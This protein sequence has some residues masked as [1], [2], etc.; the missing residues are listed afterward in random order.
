MLSRSTA[1]H[2]HARIPRRLGT[3]QSYHT[4][5]RTKKEK[6]GKKIL[7]SPYSTKGKKERKE[8]ETKG[9]QNCLFSVL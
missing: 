6:K 9:K 7:S 3:Q 4:W 1:R 8:Q 2:H 5:E